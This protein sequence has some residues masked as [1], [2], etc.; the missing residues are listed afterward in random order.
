M[1]SICRSRDSPFHC[2]PGVDIF[3]ER[4]ERRGVLLRLAIE[5]GEVD[6]LAL[7]LERLAL[8][9]GRFDFERLAGDL[10]TIKITLRKINDRKPVRIIA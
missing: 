10:A 8:V 7:F 5:R 4:E 2:N 1:M 9:I 3:I 6:F